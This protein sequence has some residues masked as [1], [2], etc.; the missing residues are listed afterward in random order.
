MA[1]TRV[2]GN[3]NAVLANTIISCYLLFTCGSWL[4]IYELFRKQFES[5]QRWLAL[6][7][8]NVC[9]TGTALHTRLTSIN[10]I[11]MNRRLIFVPC[12]RDC[13]QRLPVP[14]LIFLAFPC[15]RRLVKATEV[16]DRTNTAT[17]F[18]P[19][20]LFSS[21]GRQ[22]ETQDCLPRRVNS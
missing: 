16:T 14:G 3:L 6:P 2:T 17:K 15:V 21:R 5:H 22:I 9:L 10:E 1:I 13:S 8:S 19:L 12:R 11:T 20:S 7:V 18:H 4:F